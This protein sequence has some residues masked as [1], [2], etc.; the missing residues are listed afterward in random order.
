MSVGATEDQAAV[1]FRL[2]LREGVFY[3]LLISI[4]NLVNG[5]FYLQPRQA[6]SAINIPLSV[7]LSPVLACRLILDLRERGSETVTHSDGHAFNSNGSRGLHLGILFSQQRSA[8]GSGTGGGGCRK[9]RPY[10]GKNATINSGAMLG[11]IGSD[12]G[13][14]GHDNSVELNGL[15]H[16]A[17]GDIGDDE[18]EDF[19]AAEVN[20][21]SGIRVDVE[22]TSDAI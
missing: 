9:P 16:K 13:V 14:V 3:Y 2:F 17:S 10:G 20:C 18:M 6:I 22:K 19:E 12:L 21:I 4:A 5:I 1:L 7:M 11:T 8:T 15:H